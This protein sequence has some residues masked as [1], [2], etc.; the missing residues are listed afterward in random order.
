MDSDVQG[1]TAA[2]VE[3]AMG[4]QAPA[5]GIGQ[6]II[7]N[8]D[9]LGDMLVDAIDGL[10]SKTTGAALSL[11]GGS[12]AASVSGSTGRYEDPGFE[13]KVAAAAPITPMKST[14]I[15]APSKGQVIEKSVSPH[16][17]DIVALG[18]LVAPPVPAKMQSRDESITMS[19]S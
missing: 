14:A 5:P 15:E 9:A 4:L 18:T 7:K 1:N 19:Y 6:Q 2:T 8:L 17:V 12:A 11:L 16:E 3:P 10:L 13:P